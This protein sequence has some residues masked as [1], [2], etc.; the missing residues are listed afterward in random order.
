MTDR[1]MNYVDKHV[2]KPRRTSF[3]YKICFIGQPVSLQPKEGNNGMAILRVAASAPLVAWV[4][5]SA[6]EGG[7]LTGKLD[8]DVE[9]TTE[10][11]L[12]RALASDRVL[13]QKLVLILRH[14]DIMSD[15][16]KNG[17]VV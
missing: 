8:Y 14:W 3:R 11:A 5:K 16:A 7:E 2:S 17:I 6:A 1:S 12:R 10:I 13:L 15:V 9:V 4:Y